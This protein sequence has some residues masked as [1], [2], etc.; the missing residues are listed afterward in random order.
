MFLLIKVLNKQDL[1][2]QCNSSGGLD[3]GRMQ[4]RG[5]LCQMQSFKEDITRPRHSIET[6]VSLRLDPSQETVFGFYGKSTPD[7]AISPNDW[8]GKTYWFLPV[9]LVP[10][11]GRV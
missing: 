6:S 3:D 4:L 7:T 10:K 9:R 5:L 8:N 2:L 11:K 1:V